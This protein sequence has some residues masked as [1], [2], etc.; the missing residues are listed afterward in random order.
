[1]CRQKDEYDKDNK[2]RYSYIGVKCIK[3]NL[4][5]RDQTFMS[6]HIPFIFSSKHHKQ[7]Y[8][9]QQSGSCMLRESGRSVVEREIKLLWHD[10][11]SI[12]NS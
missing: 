4:L 3:H 10:I 12:K 1:V 2:Y 9:W 5:I 7:L 6:K 11:N 8:S